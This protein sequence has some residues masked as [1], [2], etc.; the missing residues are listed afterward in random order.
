MHKPADEERTVP[1]RTGDCHSPATTEEKV[2]TTEVEAA[3]T[4]E[5]AATAQWGDGRGKGP[6]RTRKI[7]PRSLKGKDVGGHPH[8]GDAIAEPI[9]S[10]PT[11]GERPDA[12]HRRN[13]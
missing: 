12:D 13:Q 4:E 1:K 6:E 5:M 11:T 7:H 3:I 8:T 9:N 10:G 2:A